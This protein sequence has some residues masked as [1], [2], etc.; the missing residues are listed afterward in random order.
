MIANIRDRRKRPLRWREVNAIIEATSHDNACK[1]SDQQE[2]T[3]D[4]VTYDERNGISV[5][6]AIEWASRESTAVTLYLYDKGEGTT[7]RE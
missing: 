5:G 7:V 6:E 2:P 3:G 1:D 4:D